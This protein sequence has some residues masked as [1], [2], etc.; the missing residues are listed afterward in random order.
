GEQG[1]KAPDRSFEVGDEG[2]DRLLVRAVLAEVELADVDPVVGVE[3]DVRQDPEAGSLQAAVGE[4]VAV[5]PEVRGGD[6]AGALP[7]ATTRRDRQAREG[8][9]QR[10]EPGPFRRSEPALLQHRLLGGRRYFGAQLRARDE[11]DE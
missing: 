1:A 9:R 2:L 5:L 11:G 10:F 4:E 8:L 3:A 6:A 7:L